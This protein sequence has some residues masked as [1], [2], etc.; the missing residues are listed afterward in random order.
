MKRE[1]D[2]LLQDVK[3]FLTDFDGVHTDGMVLVDQNGVEAVRCSRR[4]GL[5]F[6]ML[7]KAGIPAYIISKETNP[8]VLARAKK[9]NISCY[10][11][12]DT[13]DDKVS[14]I[15]KIMNEHACEAKNVLYI[16]DDINDLEA[17][18]FVGVPV[19]VGDCHHDVRVHAKIITTANGGQHAV[20]EVID[21]LLNSRKTH[22]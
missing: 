3:L 11:G 9:L 6:D 1:I 22:D 14:I 12:V 21:L 10:H 16:G 2:N 13:G 4:D 20:R 17:L 19:T 15:K 7:K 18:K 8:V 5:G